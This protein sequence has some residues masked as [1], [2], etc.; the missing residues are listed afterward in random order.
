MQRV[1][2]GTLERNLLLLLRLIKKSIIAAI[3]QVDPLEQGKNLVEFAQ[4]LAASLFVKGEDLLFSKG[5]G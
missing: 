4:N 1:W 2:K 3:L 5:S